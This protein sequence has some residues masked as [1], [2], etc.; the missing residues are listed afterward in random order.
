MLSTNA[1]TSSSCPYP[2]RR[3]V[4]HKLAVFPGRPG[5]YILGESLRRTGPG[6]PGREIPGLVH[7]DRSVPETGET[8]AEAEHRNLCPAQPD[9]L[10]GSQSRDECFV[11]RQT[12]SQYPTPLWT[13]WDV[14]SNPPTTLRRCLTTE[15]HCRLSQW[16][17]RLSSCRLQP[18]VPFVESN[19]SPRFYRRTRK[20]GFEPSMPHIAPSE[21]TLMSIAVV[22]FAGSSCHWSAPRYS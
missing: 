17:T 16:P 5:R 6:R 11:L 9:S 22:L 12:G 2:D 10:P 20:P 19:T 21:A 18:A 7:R 15:W 14:R 1:N 13:A 3:N 4:R 8:V